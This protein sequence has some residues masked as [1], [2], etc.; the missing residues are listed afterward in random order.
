MPPE[1][2]ESHSLSASGSGAISML[3]QA[4]NESGATGA[5]T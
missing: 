5:T 1:Q 2:F 4:R 3:H